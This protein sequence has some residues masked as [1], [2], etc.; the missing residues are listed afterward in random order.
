MSAIGIVGAG[1]AG[2]AA[3]ALYARA[4]HDVQVLE[5]A[6]NPGPVGA[7][8]LL[9]P[10][11]IGVLRRLGVLDEVAAGAARVSEVV[12]TTVG[13]RRFMDLAY[14]GLGEEVHGLGVHRG[15]LFTALR[16]AAARA[17]AAL[18]PGVEIVRRQDR[19][20]IDAGGARYGPYDRIVGA[21]GARSAM[22]RFLP[23]RARIHDH[24]WGALW[25]IFPDAAGSFDGRL[26]QY[27]DGA[28][29][30]VGFLPTGAGAVS[31]FWSVRLDRIDAVR[32]AG[33]GAFRADLLSLAPVAEPVLGGLTSMEQLMPASYRQV[34]LPAWH[35]GTLVLVGDAAHALSPQLGQGANLA[36][37]DAA[38]LVDAES[39]DAFEAARRAQARFY[40]FGARALNVVFQNDLDLAAWPRDRLMGPVSRMP[41][42]RRRA[43]EVLAGIAA[44]P[45]ASI[46]T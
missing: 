4:G 13:G 34:S 40:G 32:T 27:F 16:G 6:P 26:D 31:I 1:T 37:M 19:T 39:L 23:V 14:A 43:L 17:G 38:A 5:R 45:F 29:R 12:G 7:G 18:L 8:L 28:S 11:G 21:D 2:L 3:A 20:L 15:A 30:M 9:Q 25:G 46:K 44:G 42:V 22:R 41:W 10:T 24:R 33:V 35:D 36:L